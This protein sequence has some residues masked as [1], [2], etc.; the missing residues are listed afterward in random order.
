M[1]LE[2]TA[3]FVIRRIVAR[4]EKD[5]LIRRTALPLLARLQEKVDSEEEG[6]GNGLGKATG[7]KPGSQA[8]SGSLREN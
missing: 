1:D 6:N 4:Y 3:I 2:L 8:V 7:A 5:S